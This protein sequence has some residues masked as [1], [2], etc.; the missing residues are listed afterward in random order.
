MA[1]FGNLGLSRRQ[2]TPVSVFS[3]RVLYLALVVGSLF[4]M[5]SCAGP[6]QYETVRIKEISERYELTVPVSQLILTI[7]KGGLQQKNIAIGGATDNPRYFY[8][9]DMSQRLILSGWFEEEQKFPGLKKFWGE[10]TKGWNSRGPLE[11]QDVSFV[12]NGGKHEGCPG[13]QAADEDYSELLEELE[14]AGDLA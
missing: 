6:S 9:E 8:F 2:G 10:T 1:C 11:P 5:I 12:K 4:F 13:P 3:V 14:E 7:P